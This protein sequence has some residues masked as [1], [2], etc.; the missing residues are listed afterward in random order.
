MKRVGEAQSL[1][2][3]DVKPE[4]AG[5]HSL[6]APVDAV[7]ECLIG[8]PTRVFDASKVEGAIRIRLSTE[9]RAWLLFEEQAGRFSWNHRY[10]R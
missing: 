3:I 6:T 8:Q 10:C 7:I 5:I 1:S 9:E 2:S 4:A